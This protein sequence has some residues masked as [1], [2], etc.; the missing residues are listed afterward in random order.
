MLRMKKKEQPCVKKEDG[1]AVC[2]ITQQAL[3]S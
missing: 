1:I 2:V 3:K